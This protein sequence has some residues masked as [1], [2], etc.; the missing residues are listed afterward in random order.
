MGL[1]GMNG[2]FTTR[3]F[4]VLARQPKALRLVASNQLRQTNRSRMTPRARHQ[5]TPQWPFW[6]LLTAWACANT[7]Q[8]AVF[9]AL[10][11]L[12]EGRSFTHQQRLTQDVARL[13]VGEQPT[14][15]VAD[16]VAQAEQHLPAKPPTQIPADTVM[17]KLELSLE[18]TCDILPV[19]L[20]ATYRDEVVWVFPG[21][22]RVQPPHRPPRVSLA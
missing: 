12:A 2:V 8:I 10:S 15:P 7:P 16:A 20:R 11:W 9:A 13:L 14:T 21:S 18:T 3:V 17:K 6:L 1:G 22:R 4:P 19:C 5:P